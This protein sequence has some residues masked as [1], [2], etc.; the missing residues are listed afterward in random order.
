LTPATNTFDSLAMATPDGPLPTPRS[1]DDATFEAIDNAIT[2]LGLHRQLWMGDPRNMIHLLA[3][4]IDQAQRCLPELV[5]DARDHGCSWQDIAT[6]LGTSPEQAQLRY[7]PDSPV[8][9][10]RWMLDI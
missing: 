7:D 5:A 4:L 6:L 1:G 10:R 8:A 3:S 2:T 9:D